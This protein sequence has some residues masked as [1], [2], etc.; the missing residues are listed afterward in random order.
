MDREMARRLLQ[1]L[2]TGNQ[3]ALQDHFKARALRWESEWHAECH[4]CGHRM[5][6]LSRRLDF[7]ELVL[8]FECS[9]CGKPNRVALQ[10]WTEMEP[11]VVKFPASVGDADAV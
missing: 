6:P 1:A 8:N 11:P 9:L 4:R 5:R 7:D 2:R 3:Q 10:D